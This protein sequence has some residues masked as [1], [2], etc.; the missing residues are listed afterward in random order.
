MGHSRT[1]LLCHVVFGTKYRTPWIEERFEADL[2]AYIGG[3]IERKGS[4]VIQIG[5]PRYKTVGWVSLTIPPR[6]SATR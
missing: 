4:H 5:G 6:I 3:I 2:Y 1:D